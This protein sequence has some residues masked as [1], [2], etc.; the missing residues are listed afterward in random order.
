M[1]VI[2]RKKGEGILL[3]DDIEITVVK[4]EEG[5]VKISISAPKNVAILRK[6]LYKEV[7]SENEKAVEFDSSLLKNIKNKI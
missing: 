2:T 5:S 1:L 6:E 3:G 4:I 7:K